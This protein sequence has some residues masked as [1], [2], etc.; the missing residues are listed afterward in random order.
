MVY[1]PCYV[2]MV[3]S[4]LGSITLDP[5][6]CEVAQEWIRADTFYTVSDNGL[7]QRWHGRVFLNPP[8]GKNGGISNQAVWSG[9]M[10][11]AWE[12]GAIEAGLLLINSTH[13]Y[14]WYEDLWTRFPVCLL[15]ERVRF[16]RPDGSV[17]GRAKRGQ[18]FVYFGSDTAGFARVFGDAGRIIL[19]GG[20]EWTTNPRK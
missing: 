4:V 6:S 20:D 12:A 14:R 10:V 2:E 3:R 15:R 17:G 16:I 13:G 8:Y 5:A 19:P 18:T 9:R 11:D 1:P 7:T